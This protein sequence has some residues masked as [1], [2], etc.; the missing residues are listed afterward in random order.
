[1]NALVSATL[2][3]QAESGRRPWG[4]PYSIWSKVTLL[5]LA[6]SRLVEADLHMTNGCTAT[7]SS[8]M[9]PLAGY[10]VEPLSQSEKPMVGAAFA[11]VLQLPFS[12]PSALGN[13]RRS[14]FRVDLSPWTEPL[15]SA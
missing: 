13:V 6:I 1:M 5:I 10:G 2:P 9:L 8:L 4:M 14:F 12:V 15:K 11:Y 7:A 3:V